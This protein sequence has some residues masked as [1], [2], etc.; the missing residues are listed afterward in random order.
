MS[1]LKN[2]VKRFASASVGKGYMTS[3]ER[4]AKKAAKVKAGKTKVF[5]NAT[6]P[7]ELDIRRI[8][9]RKSAKRR[10]ARAK[11]ILTEDRDR[12]G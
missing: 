10:S 9:R 7:D 8:E 4:R 6:L 12:L 5:A 3:D 2:T 1:G 11:T